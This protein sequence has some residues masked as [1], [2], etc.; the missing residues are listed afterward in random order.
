MSSAIPKGTP[1]PATPEAPAPPA[2][3][4]DESPV[5]ITEADT[6]PQGGIIPKP[7]SGVAPTNPGDRGGAYQWL[8]FGLMILFGAVAF[9][10]VRRTAKRTQAARAAASAAA[11]A[12]SE[13]PSS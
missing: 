9:T 10:S 4:S 2:Q 3:D 7:N 12:S 13:Q 5:Q 1:A 6:Q 11:A 8:L